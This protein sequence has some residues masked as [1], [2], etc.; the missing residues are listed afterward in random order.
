M[1]YNRNRGSRHATEPQDLL[2]MN[3]IAAIRRQEQL[4]RELQ[5]EAARRDAIRRGFRITL[6]PPPT[7]DLTNYA[8]GKFI[9]TVNGVPTLTTLDRVMANICVVCRRTMIERAEKAEIMILECGHG[10]C[11]NCL[12]KLLFDHNSN[13]CPHCQDPFYEVALRIYSA[14]DF[15]IR[16][17]AQLRYYLSKYDFASETEVD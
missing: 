15:Q 6:L 11:E 17:I 12:R 5:R 14:T 16:S 9:R 10:L 13:I 3:R 2:E 1:A 7:V 8:I 4:A